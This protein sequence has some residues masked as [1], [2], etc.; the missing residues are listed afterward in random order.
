MDRT[1]KILGMLTLLELND[2]Q[3]CYEMTSLGNKINNFLDD[4]SRLI[5]AQWLS[6]M[7]KSLTEENESETVE[8]ITNK[9]F[10]VDVYETVG[11]DTDETCEI[12]AN[13]VFDKSSLGFSDRRFT[14]VDELV[15]V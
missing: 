15:A 10:E 11:K 4:Q 7:Y 5:S 14:L 3:F 12:D 1:E 8:I 6:V 13:D 2:D 9:P